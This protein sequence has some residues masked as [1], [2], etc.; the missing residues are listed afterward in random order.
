MNT[1]TKKLLVLLLV[2]ISSITVAQTSS[3]SEYTSLLKNQDAV[4]V[5]INYSDKQ[6]NEPGMVCIRFNNYWCIKSPMGQPTYWNG[7]ESQDSRGHAQFSHPKYAARA[8]VKLMHTYYFKHNL[9]SANDIMNRY[10]PATDTIGSMAG[11]KPNP[12]G[13]Y[14]S[15]IA[16]ELGKQADEDLQL[17]INKG[18]INR[19][20]MVALLIVLAKW[21]ITAKHR[22]TE[23]LAIDGIS[24]AGF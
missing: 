20:K 18:T 2:S 3:T 24:L 12:T 19:D 10:A 4:W 11:G 5:P 22:V 21:E 14:A 9:R 6:L 13:A 23:E 15:Q 8:F 17:F 16:N 7:Q 1:A